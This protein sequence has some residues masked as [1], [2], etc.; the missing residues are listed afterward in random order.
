MPTKLLTTLLLLTSTTGLGQVLVDAATLELSR[1]SAVA[2]LKGGLVVSLKTIE[3]PLG[4]RCGAGRFQA[5]TVIVLGRD[6]EVRTR[7]GV[8]RWVRVTLAGARLS[9]QVR[10]EQVE[11]EPLAS[12]YEQSSVAV[13]GEEAQSR[14]G[15]LKLTADGRYRLGRAEG[16]WW[17][18][19]ARIA[20]DGPLAHWE[21]D[22]GFPGPG[23]R[24][25]YSRGPLQFRISYSPAGQTASR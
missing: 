1:P 4:V 12:D 5:R 14:F 13:N 9:V 18:D 6:C 10:T 25:S 2:R 3:A 23:L 15:P 17:R 11:P 21:G 24:F 19:G 22:A 7:S 20:F 8:P 16:R